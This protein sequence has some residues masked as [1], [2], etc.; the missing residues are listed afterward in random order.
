LNVDFKTDGG[1]VLHALTSGLHNP[2]PFK[3]RIF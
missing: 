2:G 1:E 3:D